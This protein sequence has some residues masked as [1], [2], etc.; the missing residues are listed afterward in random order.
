MIPG[1]TFEG[2]KKEIAAVIEGSRR[3]T[4]T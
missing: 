2:V 1:E 4:P 3:P